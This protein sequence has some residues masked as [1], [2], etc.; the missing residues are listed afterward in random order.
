LKRSSD[1]SLMVQMNPLPL[2]LEWVICR[3]TMKSLVIYCEVIVK[4]YILER[5]RREEYLWRGYLN[6]QY[7]THLKFIH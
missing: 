7:E 5:I 2:W 3:F 6:G 4:I 1:I